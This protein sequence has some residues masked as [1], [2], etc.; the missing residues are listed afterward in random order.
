MK[1]I[2][3]A[4]LPRDV[5][6]GVTD[7]QRK[8]GTIPIVAPS[9]VEIEI[10][11]FFGKGSLHT[12]VLH[13]ELVKKSSTT[14]L[15]S[16]NEKVGQRSRWSGSRSPQMPSS[17]IGLLDASLHNPSFLS[18]VR[19]Y[20]KPIEDSGHR[21]Y[22]GHFRISV[23]HYYSTRGPSVNDKFAAES[24]ARWKK[25]GRSTPTSCARPRAPMTSKENAI[26]PNPC[27][28]GRRSGIEVFVWTRPRRTRTLTSTHTFH[29]SHD[30]V[31]LGAAAGTP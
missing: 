19:T 15:R 16:D 11:Y 12:R 5:S 27:Q 7:L 14:L 10:M 22:A 1:Q 8:M 6:M 29:E 31:R 30:L 20:Y 28:T 18:Q 21:R 24:V 3:R 9:E 23:T 25:A 26:C 13:Q 2:V 17:S 4:G